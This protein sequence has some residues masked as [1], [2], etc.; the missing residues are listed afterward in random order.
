MVE[1]RKRKDT[2]IEVYTAY[3][4]ASFP[5]NFGYFDSYF[6]YCQV[7]KMQLLVYCSAAFDYMDDDASQSIS[8]TMIQLYKLTKFSN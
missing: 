2:V 8:H 4:I 7:F 3:R 5:K 6:T 1:S